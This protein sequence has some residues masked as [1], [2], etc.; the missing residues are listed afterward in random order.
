MRFLFLLTY[1]GGGSSRFAI[2][3]FPNS[4]ILASCSFVG[5]PFVICYDFSI[6]KFLFFNDRLSNVSDAVDFFWFLDE[7]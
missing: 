3:Q 6:V 7:Y 5:R 4:A 2:R 1:A